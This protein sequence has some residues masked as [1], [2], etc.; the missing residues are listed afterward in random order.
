M[1]EIAIVGAGYVGLPLAEAFAAAGRNVVLVEIDGHRVETINSGE[2]HVEDV[3][4]DV[5][6]PHVEAGRISAT[7]DYDA[8][9]EAE[10]IVVALPTPLSPNRE[11]DLSAVLDAAGR[12]GERL[13]GGQLVV[14]ESTTYPGTTREEVLPLL[15]SS[16]LE[17]GKDFFLAYS[18]ERVDPGRTDWTMKTTPKVVGGVT[19]ACT[20]RARELYRGAVDTVLAVS[21]PEAAELA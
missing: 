17:V 9:R 7:A 13:R 10:A 19:P 4:S 2:S 3:P 14:L 12:I 18:P 11:P 20:E 5:L 6:R 15:E 1:S 16:G 21:S 8:V